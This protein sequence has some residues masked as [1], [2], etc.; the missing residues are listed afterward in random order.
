VEGW[1]YSSSSA[2]RHQYEI[3]KQDLHH[4]QALKTFEE[5]SSLLDQRLYRMRL[6]FW[7]GATP[8][9]DKPG[10]IALVR[11]DGILAARGTRN[12]CEDVIGYLRLLFRGREAKQ[13]IEHSSQVSSMG[14]LIVT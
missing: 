8:G 7:A 12:D 13:A 14:E 2:R 1:P 11:P 4:Q 3:Q 10:T 6:I 5:L 9:K